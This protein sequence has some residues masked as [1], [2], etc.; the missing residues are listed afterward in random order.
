MGLRQKRSFARKF[1]QAAAIIVLLLPVVLPLLVIVL[2]LVV[3]ASVLQFLNEIIVYLLVWLCWLRKGKDILFVSSD[4]PV[5]KEYMNTE[6][7][8]L[9]AERAIVLNWS[10]R[11]KWSKLSLPVRVF[12]KFGGRRNYNPIVVLFRPLRRARVF[13]FLPALRDSKHGHTK[14]IEQL[15]R[16][17]ILALD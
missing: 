7:L 12:R 8:S 6:I 10:E 9:V 14:N 5:W 4:S 11:S 13:R 16:E 2:P 15:R 17:L 3:I 1:I